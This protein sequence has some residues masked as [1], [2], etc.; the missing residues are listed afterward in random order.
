M[1]TSDH[2]NLNPLLSIFGNLAP[3]SVLD[4]GCGFGKYGMLLREYLDIWHQRL[5]PKTWQVRLVGLEAFP[6]YRNP[7]HDYVYDEVIY[8]PAVETLPHVGQFDAVL[9]AD[10]IEH[11]PKLEAKALVAECFRHSPVVV[12]STPK[13]FYAQPDINGN[14]FEQHHHLWTAMDFPREMTVRT[15]QVVSCNIF[16]ASREPLPSATFGLTDPTDYIYLRSREKLGRAGL[17]LSV[18]LRWLCR[19]LG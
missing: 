15:I 6:A 10:M 11:L 2:H 16:V 18:G 3:R 7:I 12:I 17:P 14:P 19:L 4:I 8:G 1:P 9:I 5:V 13:E